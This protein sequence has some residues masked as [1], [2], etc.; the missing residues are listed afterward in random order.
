MT[1]PSPPIRITGLGLVTPVGHSPWSAFRALLDGRT[2]ADRLS[3]IPDGAG[4][5]EIA[6]ATASIPASSLTHED[7]AIPL[8]ET[9]A[10]QALADAGLSRVDRTIVAA[11]KGAVHALTSPE[12]TVPPRPDALFPR[13]VTQTPHGYL[14]N[15]IARRL[16]PTHDLGTISIPVAAC[17]TSLVGLHQALRALRAGRADS[18]L[19][20]TVESSLSTQFVHSYK[21]LGV[22]APTDPISDHRARPLDENRHGFTL[23]EASAA[24][25]LQ[26]TDDRAAPPRSHARLHD[27][28]IGTEPHDVL[29]APESF[30]TLARLTRQVLTGAPAPALVHP[31]ATGTPDNDARELAALEA[32]L[33]SS[34]LGTRVYASKGAIGHSMG[35]A[36]L[37][38]VVL[39]CLMAR[40]KR[41]PPMPWLD[42]PIQSAFS[43]QKAGQP[44]PDGSHL[45]VSAGF[46]GHTAAAC[47]I[48]GE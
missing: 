9:A 45:I 8:A 22:L 27:T 39:T 42:S 14:A 5:T 38:N 32:A 3:E 34:A 35:A 21:R 47:L 31:H 13:I 1:A 41:T 4:P 17:A 26:R 6:R 36:G 24:I 11:S 46:G 29:R 43:L 20:I 25:V 37:I 19:L 23:C 44:L 16:G 18:V 30:D 33:A 2:T 10:K 28:A 12:Q 15:S 48:P 40:A 7:P